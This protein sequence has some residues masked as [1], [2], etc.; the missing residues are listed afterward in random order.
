MGVFHFGKKNIEGS[1]RVDF[2]MYDKE[3]GGEQCNGIK[4]KGEL[5]GRVPGGVTSSKPRKNKQLG[6]GSK[7]VNLGLRRVSFGS[8]LSVGGAGFKVGMGRRARDKNVGLRSLDP[9]FHFVVV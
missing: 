8:G 4:D 2:F 6:S 1:K 5:N 7:E 3:A 9:K